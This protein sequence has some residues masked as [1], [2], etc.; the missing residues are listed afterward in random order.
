MSRNNTK[1]TRSGVDSALNI[2][3]DELMTSKIDH[4]KYIQTRL[5]DLLEEA[6]H[7]IS[8]LE[9]EETASGLNYSGPDAVECGCGNTFQSGGKYRAKC[10]TFTCE[11]SDGKEKCVDC[12]K[13]CCLCENYMCHSCNN[14]GK[15]CSS[16]REPLCKDCA[17]E[18]DQCG[19]N[20]CNRTGHCQMI[21][22]GYEPCCFYCKSYCA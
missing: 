1:R 17:A 5:Q 4:C 14:N 3:H 18:C 6:E 15:G 21:S 2:L 11:N 16:C 22:V 13:K 7:K 8:L 9:E 10:S 20:Y 19:G 12:L